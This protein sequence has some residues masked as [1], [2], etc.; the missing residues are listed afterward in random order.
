[1]G[2]QTA[3][4]WTDHTFNPWIGCEKVSQECKNCYAEAYALRWLASE[5][6]WGGARSDRHMTSESNWNKLFT[7]NKRAEA[8]GKKEFVFCASLADW[9]EQ[10]DALI[11]HGA[12]SD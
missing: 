1:M 11:R 8:A 3:I 4:E 7:W 9:A 5:K 6:L 2:E 12:K 10:R